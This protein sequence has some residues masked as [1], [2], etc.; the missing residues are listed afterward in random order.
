MNR[1]KNILY[2]SEATNPDQASAIGRA[3]SL[4]VNNQAKLTVIAVIPP[5][6]D[7]LHLQT[8][9]KHMQTLKSLIEPHRQRL[10]I[11]LDVVMGRVFLE[12]IRA[13]LRNAHDLVIKI[14][15]NPD[16]L[17]RL[18][19]SDDMHLLRKC[20][21]PVWLMKPPEKANYSCIMAAVD[22][23]PLKPSAVEQTLNQQIV[24][25]A[26]SLA[27]SDFATLH[28]VHAWDAFA[29]GSIRSR[30]DRRIEGVADYVE[31]ERMLHENGLHM[32]G[33]KLQEQIGGDAYDYLSPQFHLP[34]GPAKKVIASLAA[35]MQADLVVIGTVARTGISGFF[36]GNTAEAI[37]DQ[38]TC[39]VLAIKPPGFITPVKLVE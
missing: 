7:A 9:E 34:K 12:V 25:L 37:L 13:V 17:Q 4:A 5:V 29:E 36:I 18:F 28:L 32:L 3:V 19:G 24:E 11:Q 16:F 6:I 27:L 20:P 1:F 22:F 38:L 15:E 10:E 14:G 26:S 8:M 35:G 39:S 23:D 33:E 31:K 21:C 2:V 30:G